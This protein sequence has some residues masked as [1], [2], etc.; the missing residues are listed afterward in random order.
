MRNLQ[1]LSLSRLPQPRLAPEPFMEFSVDLEELRVIK[2]DLAIIKNHA[3]RH[4]RGLKILDLSENK[5]T[6]IE[7]E[8]F[9][10]VM[11]CF[12]AY[13]VDGCYMLKGSHC[14]FIGSVIACAL[15]R[16]VQ[17]TLGNLCMQTCMP[18]AIGQKTIWPS[19]YSNV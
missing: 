17:R 11:F 3:F 19:V 5:I 2:S 8:A 15:K 10:E 9:T 14:M 7:N 6:Q 4:V 1:F 12:K 13:G 16:R 18:A